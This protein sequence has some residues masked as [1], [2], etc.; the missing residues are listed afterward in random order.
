MTLKKPEPFLGHR[1]HKE[2]SV[3][4]QDVF[5]A[6]TSLFRTETLTEVQKQ[7][8]IAIKTQE[9]PVTFHAANV[10]KDDCL[11]ELKAKVDLNQKD[12]EWAEKLMN[13][14]SKI[15]EVRAEIQKEEKA[16]EILKKTPSASASSI[17]SGMGIGGSSSGGSSSGGK[18]WW[19]ILLEAILGFFKGLIE[20]L[21]W[22]LKRT[23]SFIAKAWKIFYENFFKE[24]AKWTFEQ[25][26]DW[27]LA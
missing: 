22:I 14:F 8:F 21:A 17:L 7:R 6:F 20:L 9:K 13:G 3:T 23:G 10:L 18:P 24:F 27:L 1:R 15:D 2:K 4:F 12:E 19:K 25:F 11:R 16:S 5:N 26:K